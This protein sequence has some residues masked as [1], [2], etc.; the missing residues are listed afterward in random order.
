M[1]DPCVAEPG[2]QLPA[3]GGGVLETGRLASSAAQ[4][5]RPG[6]GCFIIVKSNSEKKELTGKNKTIEDT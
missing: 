5:F 3:T 2:R 1:W 6:S 4:I